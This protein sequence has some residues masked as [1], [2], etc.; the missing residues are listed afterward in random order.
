MSLRDGGC[1]LDVTSAAAAF[2][3]QT[4]TVTVTRCFTDAGQFAA[5]DDDANAAADKQD[6]TAVLLARG[7]FGCVQF[8]RG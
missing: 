4:P 8:V 7:S 5:A 6:G 2:G 3:I 1:A